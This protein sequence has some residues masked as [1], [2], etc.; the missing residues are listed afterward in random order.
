[1]DPDLATETD[2]LPADFI[3]GVD[4]GYVDLPFEA[5]TD[6]PQ[7]LEY[8]DLPDVQYDPEQNWRDAQVGAARRMIGEFGPADE[9]ATDG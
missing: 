4:D 2:L 9:E 3:S 5:G 7:P 6:D 1:M 8:A